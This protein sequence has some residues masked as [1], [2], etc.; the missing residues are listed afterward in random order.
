MFDTILLNFS[1]KY[2]L[3]PLFQFEN[4]SIK[5]SIFYDMEIFVIP[6]PGDISVHKNNFHHGITIV[7]ARLKN[8]HYS[9]WCFDLGFDRTSHWEIEYPPPTIFQ[10]E[11]DHSLMRKWASVNEKAAINTEKVGDNPSI[12]VWP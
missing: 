5:L 1:N 11:S 6:P 4:W 12:E 2:I 7:C 8:T 3:F 9:R 10:W